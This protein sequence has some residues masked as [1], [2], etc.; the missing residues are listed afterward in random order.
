MT[1]KLCSC[2]TLSRL[3]YA[4]FLSFY[5]NNVCKTKRYLPVSLNPARG[6][7]S[8]SLLKFLDNVNFFFTSDGQFLAHAAKSCSRK[9][10]PEVHSFKFTSFL[11]PIVS[12]LHSRHLSHPYGPPEGSTPGP[13]LPTHSLAYLAQFQPARTQ[14]PE[15]EFPAPSQPCIANLSATV[16]KHV[17]KFSSQFKMELLPKPNTEN[18]PSL[19][20]LW[21]SSILTMLQDRKWPT[22]HNAA[23]FLIRSDFRLSR[24]LVFSTMAHFHL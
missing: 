24:R 11:S 4:V 8:Q 1:Y 6:S 16:A 22:T 15:A 19:K 3:F 2:K 12:H 13:P 10:H 7:K 23:L 21:I 5:R 9:I 18:I 20:A 17:W 14:L